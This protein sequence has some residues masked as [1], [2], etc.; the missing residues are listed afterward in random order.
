MTGKLPESSS[1]TTSRHGAASP[2]A[3]TALLGALRDTSID[4]VVVW[5]IDRLV[6]SMRDL[7]DV[8]DL[9]RP[10]WTC[11]AGEWDL[12]T[13]AGRAIARTLT[14]WGRYESDVKSRR[15]R[16]KHEQLAQSGAWAS[17]RCFGYTLEGQIVDAE[18]EVIRE[19]A[20]RL[21]AGAS[22]RSVTKW[23]GEARVPTIRGGA[24]RGS[25]VRQIMTAARLS[26][27]REWTPRV[28]GR[29]TEWE[30]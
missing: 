5:H 14:A 24:W 3:Y 4:G 23:L 12:S 6:R 10:V 26:S 19:I 29:D 11:V 13:D 18:A 21:L 15:L 20:N 7:E 17:G 8:I 9:D 1:T 2:T 28:K 30:R 22:L 25:T 16:A 27:Q